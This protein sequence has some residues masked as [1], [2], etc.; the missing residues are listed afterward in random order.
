LREISNRLIRYIED[1]DSVCERAAVVQEELQSQLAE[2]MNARM[3]VLSVVAVVFLPLGF[4]TGL[5]G[6]NLGGIPGI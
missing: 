4:L 2:Q 1:K 5:V 3:Y 6:V